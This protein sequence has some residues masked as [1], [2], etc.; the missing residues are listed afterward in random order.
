MIVETATLSESELGQ[1]CREKGLFVEQV[2][3]WKTDCLQGFSNK[4]EQEQKSRQ[5]AKIDKAEIKTLKKELR[6]KENALAETAALLVLRK[7]L[8]ALWQEEDGDD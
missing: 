3:R 7:N 8:S 2:K 1:Y 4:K 6:I 5:Q